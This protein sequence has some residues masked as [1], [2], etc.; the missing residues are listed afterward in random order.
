M[1]EFETEREEALYT[2]LRKLLQNHVTSYA[3]A[4]HETMAACM[5]VLGYI[6]YVMSDTPEETA[7]L[8]ETTI[9]ELYPR[10]HSRVEQE[11]LPL[12][13]FADYAPRTVMSD[14]AHELGTALATYLATSGIEY[15]MSVVATWRAYLAL[16]AD[17]L[18]M[19]LHEGAQTLEEVEADIAALRDRLPAVMQMW[20]EEEE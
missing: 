19:P 7:G 14:P 3:I 2:T 18:V 1:E 6:L 20:G 16:V 12:A 8:V 15:N 13:S 9:A 11:H 4:Y 10:L 5:S 17:L